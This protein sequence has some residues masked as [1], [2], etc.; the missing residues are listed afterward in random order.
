M[1]R[2]ARQ[3]SE[4]GIYHVMLRGINQQ[5][6]F[7]DDED[8]QRFLQ[9]LQ[10]YKAPCGY[11]VYAYCLMGNHVHLLLKEGKEELSLVFKRIAGSYAYWYNWKYHRC[12]HL[13]QDRFKSEPVEDDGYFLMVLRYIHQNPV[14]AGICRS[15]E[16]YAY[17]SMREY[18]SA[19]NLADTSF[20]FSMIS[21]EEFLEY[22]RD[23]NTDHCLE[24]E[25]NFRLSDDEAKRIIQKL[26]KCETASDFQK[27]D[28]VKRDSFIQMLHDRGLSV[29]QISRLTGISK[30]IVE[31]RI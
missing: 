14:K 27:L 7:E 21:A 31:T 28:T 15:A 30:R 25:E 18:L 20:V 3:K 29:R 26:T 12:G 9:T 24:I 1:P 6:I 10:N 16:D 2:M 23:E 13:F 17:S 22:H 4:S 8:R 19:S 5:Q 11:I